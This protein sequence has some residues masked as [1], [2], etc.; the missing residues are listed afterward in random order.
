MPHHQKLVYLLVDGAHARVVRRAAATGAFVTVRRVQGEYLLDEV[1]AQQQG[2]RPGRS[3]ESA[4]ESRHAVGR[5]DAYR[6]AKEN[7]AAQVG[8]AVGDLICGGGIEGVVL[9]APP[10]LLHSLRAGL[11][12]ATSVVAALGKDLIKTPDRELGTWL[13]PMALAECR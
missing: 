6:R 12:A 13:G 8:S 5:E 4:S 10:R 2:E 1:R 7:F 3:F 9:V 11:P